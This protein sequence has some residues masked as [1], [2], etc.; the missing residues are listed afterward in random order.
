MK[1]PVQV[2]IGQEETATSKVSYLV[3][4]QPK[5]K[6]QVTIFQF[7]DRCRQMLETV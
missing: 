1:V 2:F 5:V 4:T 7:L 6:Q 3:Y